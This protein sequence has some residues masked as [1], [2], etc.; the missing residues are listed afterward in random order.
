MKAPFWSLGT[1][2]VVEKNS[3]SLAGLA[4]GFFLEVPPIGAEAGTEQ[5]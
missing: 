3:V 5:P 2:D 1:C 4:L